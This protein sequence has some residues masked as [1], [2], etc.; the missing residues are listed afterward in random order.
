VTSDG[1]SVDTPAPES[2]VPDAI[3]P[4]DIEKATFRT[5]Q[6]GYDKDEVEV[7]LN[8]VAS[9]V[10]A[11]KRE[12]DSIRHGAHRPY[13]SLGREIG[14]L[15]Q[16]AHDAAAHV[17]KGA[18]NEATTM[19]QKAQ[20]DAAKARQEA[21]QLKKKY[22]TE[23]LIARDEALAAVDRL[24]EQAE[25]QR[26]FAEAEAN[27][28]H[29]EARRSARRLHDEAKKKAANIVEAATSESQARAAE[30]ERRLRRLQEFETKL[31]G[32]IE[33]LSGKLQTLTQ[34]V[35]NSMEA[36]A[37]APEARSNR[38]PRA[39]PSI[40]ITDSGTVTLDADQDETVG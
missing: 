10:R 1:S 8:A 16:H 35:K 40:R 21:E 9:D 17:R 34:Q 2:A 3:A 31:R 29:Q 37:E 6:A 39:T 38:P 33:F 25:Q 12:L 26:R 22:E 28:L 24:R 36:E 19:L 11:L 23:T 27:I 4:D 5:V 32:R 30:S 7:F 15:M 20:R 14:A 18:E 13:E